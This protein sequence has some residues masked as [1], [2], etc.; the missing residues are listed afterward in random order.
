M[1]NENGRFIYIYIYMAIAVIRGTT[2]GYAYSNNKVMIKTSDNRVTHV[3]KDTFD[4][5][6]QKL[7][8]RSAALKEDC[9]EYVEYIPDAPLYKYP[10]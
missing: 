5:L 4:Y 7:D 1:I 2:V 3:K 9:M 10:N 6:Y 8:E